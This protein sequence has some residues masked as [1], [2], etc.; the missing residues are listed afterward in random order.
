MEVIGYIIIKFAKKQCG[1]H[2]RYAKYSLIKTKKK[3][4]Q[5]DL[6]KV[7][8]I[9]RNNVLKEINKLDGFF[10]DK[11]YNQGNFKF[12]KKHMDVTCKDLKALPKRLK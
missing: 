9:D 2:F 11:S 12:L 10:I 5:W 7:G 8:V 6:V 4:Y 3:G 1:V